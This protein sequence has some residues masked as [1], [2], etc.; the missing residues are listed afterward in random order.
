MTATKG[1]SKTKAFM[2]VIAAFFVVSM[3]TNTGSGVPS[4][5]VGDMPFSKADVWQECK[6]LIEATANYE[7]DFPSVWGAL[8]FKPE[9]DI[10][11]VYANLRLQNGFGV[12]SNYKSVCTHN[13]EGTKLV[14]LVKGHHR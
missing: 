14:T 6:R 11:R 1:L 3:S 4:S 12:W 7:T 10:V 13:F 8:T 9:A 2:I 5:G